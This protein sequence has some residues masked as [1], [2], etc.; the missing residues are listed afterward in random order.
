M[1]TF[2]KIIERG[3][4]KD[5]TKTQKSITT[6]T[7]YKENHS[8]PLLPF[9]SANVKIKIFFHFFNFEILFI[10]TAPLL[11]KYTH[12]F[13]KDCIFDLMLHFHG[14]DRLGINADFTLKR[15]YI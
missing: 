6:N 13:F 5:R 11:E 4:G 10:D 7:I 9:L 1:I 2:I 15:L 12:S 3:L 8:L 14:E